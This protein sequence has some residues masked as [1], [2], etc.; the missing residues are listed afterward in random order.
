MDQAVR[1]KVSRSWVIPLATILKVTSEI[2][3]LLI[4][5][6]TGF[7]DLLSQTYLAYSHEI[8][9]YEMVSISLSQIGQDTFVFTSLLLKFSFVGRAFMQAR[10]ANI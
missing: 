9:E 4:V 3:L 2:S 6:F 8:R 1:K 7:S 5:M 10:Q